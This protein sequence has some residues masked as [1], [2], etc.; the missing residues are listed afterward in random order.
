M[1][2]NTD[3]DLRELEK[4][5]NNVKSAAE[6]LSAMQK[7]KDAYIKDFLAWIAGTK[8]IV[9]NTMLILSN[10]AKA[11]EKT[12]NP[13]FGINTLESAYKT[14]TPISKASANYGISIT[15][16]L[17]RL[18]DSLQHLHLELLKIKHSNPETSQTVDLLLS[19][20]NAINLLIAR[21]RKGENERLNLAMR[22]ISKWHNV[23]HL[24]PQNFNDFIMSFSDSIPAL[25]IS[26]TL[27]QWKRMRELPWAHVAETLNNFERELGEFLIEYDS[28]I[29]MIRIGIQET[30]VFIKEILALCKTLIPQAQEILRIIQSQTR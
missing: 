10:G 3:I 5:I 14:L 21:F 19:E 18:L 11:V 20:I 28:A 4:E 22:T 29:D 1:A 27:S 23:P 15:N 24:A 9:R 2:N 17:K 25:K 30:D 13:L 26:G 8:T 12:R 16:N 7:Q 6:M